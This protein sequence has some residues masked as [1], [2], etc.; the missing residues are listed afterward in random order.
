MLQSYILAGQKYIHHLAHAYFC[1]KIIQDK[2][3]ATLKYTNA[4]E[5]KSH[6][7][8]NFTVIVTIDFILNKPHV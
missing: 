5:Y 8:E 2:N 3:A 1:K 4:K 7:Q 6:L